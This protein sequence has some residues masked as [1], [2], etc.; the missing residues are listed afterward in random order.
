VTCQGFACRSKSAYVV[1][2]LDFDGDAY[3]VSGSAFDEACLAGL[4]AVLADCSARVIFISSWRDDLPLERQTTQLRQVGRDVAG[5]GR[6][7]PAFT[8]TPRETVVK[9]GLS[10]TGY[11]VPWHAIDDNG[12][13]YGEL[14]DRGGAEVTYGFWKSG[15]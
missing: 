14:A 13:W 15:C 2:F 12:S 8:K 7:V 4:E 10:E 1:V 6:E 11:A 9:K 5:V 3:R